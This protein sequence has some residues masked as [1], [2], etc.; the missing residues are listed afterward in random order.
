LGNGE[1]AYDF[2]YRVKKQ[3]DD[4]T[5]SLFE[6]WLIKYVHGWGDCDDFCTHAFGE[7][8]IQKP[9]L[10]IKIKSWTKNKEFWMRRAAAVILIPC[11]QNDVYDKINVMRLRICN[12]RRE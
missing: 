11:I 4:D 6:A 10:F 8:I 9:E 3:Y 5:F 12:G 2:A 7:L 1:N